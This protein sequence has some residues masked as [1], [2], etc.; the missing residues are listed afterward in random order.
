VAVRSLQLAL[1]SFLIGSPALAL[2]PGR[3]ISQYGHTMWT[4]QEGVLPGAPTDIVQTTDGY[5]WIGTRSGL[6]RFD[7]VRFVPLTPPAGEELRSNRIMALGTSSDGSLWIGTRGP[8]LTRWH[9]GHLTHYPDAPG[10]VMSVLEDRTGKVWFTRMSIRDG[11]GPLCEVVDKHA[12]CHGTADGVPLKMARQL[13]ADAQGNFWVVS[14]TTLMRWR[15]GTSRTW[16][17]PGIQELDQRNVL[18]ALQSVLPGADGSVWVGAMQPSRGLGLLRLIDDRLQPYVTPEFDGRKVSVSR[19][20][21]DR[22]KA[23]WIGTQDDGLY[24]LYDGRVSHYRS[25]D[26]LSADTIQNLFE[27]REGTLWVLTTRGIEAFRDLPVASVTSREGLSA[28]LANAVLATRDG[29]VW[30]DTWHSLDVLRGSKIT[31]LKAGHGLPGE[32]VTL[33]FEDRAGT[34]WVGID[35]DL[36]VFE[37]GKF[38]PIKQ[39]DGRPIGF[40]EGL[41]EDAAGDIWALTRDPDAS[42]WRIH[43]RKVVARVP[44]SVVPFT[45]DVLAADPHEGVWLSLQNGDLGRY[46]QDRLETVEFHR[47]PNSGVIV[48]LIARPD[49]SIVGATNLGLVG[50]RNGKS[51]TMTTANGL[52]CNDVHAL[53]TD[54]HGALWLY[55]SCGV[56]RVAADQVQAWW[57]GPNAHLSF[58]VFDALDGAQPAGANFFPTASLG[59][60]GRVWF[61]NASVV[62]MI[63]P[64]RLSGNTLPPPV[65]IEQIVADRARFAPQSGLRLAP[66]TSDLEIDYTALSFVAPRKVHFHYR[67]TGHDT[68]WQEAGGRRQAFYTDLPPGDYRF[69]VIA[70]NNDGVWNTAGATLDFSIAPAFYQ[71]RWFAVLCVAATLGAL[72]WLYLMRVRRI[73]AR[74]R[75][76]LEERVVERERIARD[77]HDTF[78]QSVQGLILKFQVV[79]LHIPEGKPRNLME[80]ALERADQVIVEGRD[81]L[82][83]LRDSTRPSDDLP[84]SLQAL[85]LELSQAGGPEFRVTIEGVPRVL[86]P[87]VREEAYRIAAEAL[88]NALHHAAARRVDTEVSYSRK[89]LSLRVVD[90]GCGFDVD[91]VRDDTPRGHFGLMGLQERAHRIQARLAVSSRPGAGTAVE[92]DVPA[93][94]AYK[95]ARA[96]I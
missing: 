22:Q 87:V 37:R 91:A 3:S 56:I 27:D 19:M 96:L 23:L 54:R 52:P 4:L 33:L 39:P 95:L 45:F 57:Q 36:T 38:E 10:S 2:D 32:E 68:D 30:I 51:Q 70:S 12:I 26:G 1:V 74:I 89:G 77:L 92:L 64:E 43:A 61:A 18:D 49:G 55:A 66:N 76:R 6:V 41:T 58:R 53:L 62:Q 40:M 63:D 5:I 60:D 78:L 13:S 86:H 44:R 93:S 65:H 83:D 25:N 35:Q 28:D 85:A 11:G 42:L 88:T 31:A 7:G 8:G 34:V 47:A 84:Q 50:W 16:L 24:R 90:D 15:G 67:L 9:A 29:A 69:Q 14:D 80:Q 82:R 20:L 75:M 79:L 72:G 17:P 48:G 46:R 21:L 73:E 94:I 59:P 81:R 71:T